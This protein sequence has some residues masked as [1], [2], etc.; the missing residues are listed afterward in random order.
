MLGKKKNEIKFNKESRSISWK[1]NR[2]EH[3]INI[4]NDFESIYRKEYEQLFIIERGANNSFET[5]I[6]CYDLDG[7]LIRTEKL[8]GRL[9]ESYI[10]ER[11][12]LIIKAHLN[13][14]KEYGIYIIN[15]YG[16]YISL[17]DQ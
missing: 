2:K 9:Y 14:M 5:Y 3:V 4:S 8:D 13:V 7:I 11:N 6:H 15:K 1:Y 17:A 10:N 16:S 12:E